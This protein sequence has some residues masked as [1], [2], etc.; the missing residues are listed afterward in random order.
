MKLLRK[1]AKLKGVFVI[2]FS[3]HPASEG[4]K[5][6]RTVFLVRLRFFRGDENFLILQ[7]NYIIKKNR[8]ETERKKYESK[9]FITVINC[10]Q[11]Q[12]K[13]RPV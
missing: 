8:S 5:R 7:D 11:P 6:E 2:C 9:Y 13:N 3:I 1:D 4:G 12:R 10:Q